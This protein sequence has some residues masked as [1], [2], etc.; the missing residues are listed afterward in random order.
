MTGKAEETKYRKPHDRLI[1]AA[2]FRPVGV[3]GCSE[4]EDKV[5]DLAKKLEGT[6]VYIKVNSALRACGF[7]LIHVLHEQGLRVFADLKLND[8]PETLGTDGVILREFKP[9]LLTVMC[10]TGVKGMIELKS[11]LP[12]TEVLGVTILTSL[13]EADTQTIYG[14]SVDEAVMRLARQAAEAKIGGFVC[15]PKEVGMIATQFGNCFTYNVPA[16]RPLCTLVPG[17][18]QNP[19]RIMTTAKALISG[20]TRL[21][22]GRPI[23]LA[24]DPLDMVKRILA[25]IEETT[26]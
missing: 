1:V 10:T 13:L 20:A 9:D 3:T 6:G 7:D 25:E 17:D 23:L 16:I 22:V 19:D 14:C 18:D 26:H 5:L 4:V 24:K 11:K 12:D 2:D 21:V 8:I 15:S